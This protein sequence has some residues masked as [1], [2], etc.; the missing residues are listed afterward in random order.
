MQE[1]PKIGPQRNQPDEYSCQSSE[2]LL[3]NI[4]RVPASVLTRGA[5]AGPVH[6]RAIGRGIRILPRV[7]ALTNA[8]PPDGCI[9]PKYG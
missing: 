9:S 5:G 4:L 3:R 6:K 7:L 1:I 8:I 2:T